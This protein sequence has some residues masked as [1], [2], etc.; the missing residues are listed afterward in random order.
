MWQNKAPMTRVLTIPGLSGSGPGHWQSLWERLDSR[1]LR[2]EQRSW[3]RP[4]LEEWVGGLEAALA[5]ESGPV[6]LVAHSLGC[7]L[8]AHWASRLGSRMSTAHGEQVL[9][10]LLVAPADVEDVARTP[11]C[12]RSFA[13]LPLRALPFRSILVA[14]RN[15]PYASFERAQRLAVAWGS[16]LVDVGEGGHLNAESQLG[17]WPEGL[18]LLRQLLETTPFALDAGLASDCVCLAESGLS[19]LLLR[20]ER[21]YP[22]LI[23]VPKLPAV[24]E[25][26]ELDEDDRARFWEESCAVARALSLDFGA[27]KLNVGMLGNQ[28]RQ[29]HVHHVARF[30]DDP[31]WPAA[32]WDQPT[33]EPYAPQELAQLR[34]RLAKGRLRQWF[35]FEAD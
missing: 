2:V 30:L 1:L 28:L 21:R 6:V 32:V 17:A 10:A 31:A 5:R 19:L 12:V 33:R 7:A 20:N 29:L 27:H 35:R 9:G 13:P 23:L 25:L 16:R 8:V 22:W 4:Q 18:A 14:S 34:E 11:D 15:D 24:S 3:E 26:F